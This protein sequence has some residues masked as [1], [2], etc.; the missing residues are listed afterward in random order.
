[1]KY[2]VIFEFETD[3]ALKYPLSCVEDGL[4]C[5][6]DNLNIKSVKELS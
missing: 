6:F 3:K 1:M 2:K 5:E 4:D